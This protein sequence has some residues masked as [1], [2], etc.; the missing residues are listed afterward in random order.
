MDGLP[1]QRRQ[2][3]QR[4]S[5]AFVLPDLEYGYTTV[6]QPELGGRELPYQRGKGLGGSSMI[7]FR[8]IREAQLQIGTGGRILLAIRNGAGEKQKGVLIKSFESMLIQYK[9][10]GI[11]V[12]SMSRFRRRSLRVKLS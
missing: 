6:P 8:F 11:V 10:M 7:N 12:A 3:Y 1:T 2:P 9:L 4:F 5:N